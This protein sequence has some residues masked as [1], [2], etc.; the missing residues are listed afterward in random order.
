MLH[1][2]EKIAL[3]LQCVHIEYKYVLISVQFKFIVSLYT[4]R[5]NQS[6]I[7]SNNIKKT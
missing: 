7:L 6:D 3:I 4:Y 1:Q 2:V 5:T